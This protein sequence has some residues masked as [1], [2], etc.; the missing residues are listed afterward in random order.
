MI[1]T[2]TFL[3]HDLWFKADL[4]GHNKVGYLTADDV[5]VYPARRHWVRIPLQIV[6]TKMRGEKLMMFELQWPDGREPDVEAFF[7]KNVLNPELMRRGMNSIFKHDFDFFDN[8]IRLPVLSPIA[9]EE[10]ENRWLQM[11][12][13]VKPCDVI[14]VIDQMSIISRLIVKLD[15]GTWSHSAIYVGDGNILEAITS[16]VV[17]RKITAYR[18]RRYRVGIYRIPGITEEQRFQMLITSHSRL[19]NRMVGEL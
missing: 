13:Y 10:H 18:N 4:T 2:C 8:P 11:I 12:Q 16:G 5:V 3:D 9:A 17:R 1:R 15:I 6:A 7:T 19:G 14:Q